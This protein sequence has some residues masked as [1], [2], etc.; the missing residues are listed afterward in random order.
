MIDHGLD[1][2]QSA[3]ASDTKS[4]P[5]AATLKS[6]K[7]KKK[8]VTHGQAHIQATYNNTIVTITDQNGNVLAWS[9]A[10]KVGFSGPKKSTPYAAAI[11]VRDLV[12]RI[13]PVGLKQIDVFVRGVG[14][15]R[16]A[17]I[18]AL[19]AQG[20]TINIIKD[21]TPMPHNGPRP[22]RVRRV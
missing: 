16:E 20:L 4:T 13:R 19:V 18:R 17:A 1:S 9:S 2:H 11:I 10:G 8:F 21:L 7:P 3:P 5:A 14:L 6:K 22:P 15:G 12:E